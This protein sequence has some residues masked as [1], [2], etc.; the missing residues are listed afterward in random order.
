M[1]VNY[2]FGYITIFIP[3]SQPAVATG[4]AIAIM[5]PTEPEGQLRMGLAN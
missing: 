2:W 4:I 1:N 5:E 3:R